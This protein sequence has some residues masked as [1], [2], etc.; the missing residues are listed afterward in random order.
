VFRRYPK[1]IERACSLQSEY[2]SFFLKNIDNY[3]KERVPAR[4][5][6]LYVN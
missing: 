4:V 2:M 6:I 5:D 3:L 1:I